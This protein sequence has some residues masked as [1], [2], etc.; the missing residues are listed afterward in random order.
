MAMSFSPTLSKLTGTDN[1]CSVAEKS[2]MN[3]TAKGWPHPS[4]PEGP[5]VQSGLRKMK[6]PLFQSN[7]HPPLGKKMPH[8]TALLI[9]L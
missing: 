3:H 2:I 5:V 9:N 7:Y 8:G 1:F 4:A 6:G